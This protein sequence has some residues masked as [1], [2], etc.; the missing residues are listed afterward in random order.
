MSHLTPEQESYV[1][2]E[3]ERRMKL[4]PYSS[5]FGTNNRFDK[6]MR[7]MDRNLYCLIVLIGTLCVVSCFFR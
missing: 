5:I 2:L 3:V 1:K 6:L 4:P 7:K